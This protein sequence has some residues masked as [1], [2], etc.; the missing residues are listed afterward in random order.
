MPQSLLRR[1]NLQGHSGRLSS[2]HLQRKASLQQM[3]DT[4]GSLPNTTTGLLH[5]WKVRDLDQAIEG[6]NNVGLRDRQVDTVKTMDPVG[7]M[8]CSI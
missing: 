2:Q 5:M 8:V 7:L 1:R 3:S 4:R 6:H